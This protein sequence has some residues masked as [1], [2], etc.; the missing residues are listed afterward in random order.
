MDREEVMNT[1][2]HRYE[3]N[4]AEQHNEKP[5]DCPFDGDLSFSSLP[6]FLFVFIGFFQN[7]QCFTETNEKVTLRD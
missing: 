1:S 5:L 2:H 6:F 4:E 3:Q 7:F